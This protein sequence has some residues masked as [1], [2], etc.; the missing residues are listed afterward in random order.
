MVAE[1]FFF[2]VAAAAVGTPAIVTVPMT[3]T[4]DPSGEM[5][6]MSPPTVIRPPAVRV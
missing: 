2:V 1:D 4:P 3:I 6:R 5:E